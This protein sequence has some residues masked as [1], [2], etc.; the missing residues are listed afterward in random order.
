MPPLPCRCGLFRYGT[1]AAQRAIFDLIVRHVFV[2]SLCRLC[3]LCRSF[4]VFPLCQQARHIDPPNHWSRQRKLP[5]PSLLVLMLGGVRKSISAERDEFLGHRQ[6]RAQLAHHVCA[7]AR[8]RLAVTAIPAL[9]FIAPCCL[10]NF[11]F[12]SKFGNVVRCLVHLLL[13]PHVC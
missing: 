2:F 6:Q 3:R 8:V 9:K 5:L 7:R 13:I 4:A 1:A 12:R 10:S 11:L